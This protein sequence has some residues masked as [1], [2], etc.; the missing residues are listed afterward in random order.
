MPVENSDRRRAGPDGPEQARLFELP[1][2]ARETASM[3]GRLHAFAAELVRRNGGVATRS[4]MKSVD[5]AYVFLDKLR[6]L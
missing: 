6:R 1:V 2:Y 4:T 3:H 5:S